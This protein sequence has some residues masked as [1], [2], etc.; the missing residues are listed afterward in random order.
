M[1]NLDQKITEQTLDIIAKAQTTGFNTSTGLYSYDL[2]P[3]LL[4]LIPVVVPFRDFVSR[5]KSTDGNKFAIWRAIMD[6]TS[7]QPDPSPGFEQAA[8][9]IVTVEQDFQAVYKPTGLGD[10]VSQDAI[11]LATGFEDPFAVSIF[12]TLNNVLIAD[13]RK[14]IGAQS[15]PLPTA[16]APVLTGLT[17][18]GSI[19]AATVAYVAAAG[20]TGSGYYYGSGNSRATASAQLTA[21]GSGAASISAIVPS[22]K[23]AVAYDW[24]YST[25]GTTWFYYTTTSTNIVTVTRVI[26]ANQPLPVNLASLSNVWQGVNGALPTANFVGDNGSANANDYDGFLATLSGDYNTAGQFVQAGTAIVNPGTTVSL[27]G[28][29]LSMSG[30]TITQIVQSLFLPIFNKTY[31]SPT[32]LMMNAAQAYEIAILVLGSTAATTFI[33]TASPERIS[34]TAGGRV[35]KIINPFG[36]GNTGGIEVAIEV[37]PAVPP[38]TIIARTDRVP[39]PNANINSVLEYRALRDTN[40]FDYGVSRATGANGGPRR[41]YEIRSLGAFVNRAPVSMGVLQNVG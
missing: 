6:A 2:S 32:V 9:Q 20:R 18:G 38:G 37:H 13:D 17:T 40:Q 12:N 23:G 26:T 5:K 1:S 41:Q 11:D 30:G 16:G 35:G 27:D 31:L 33:S 19:P 15:F 22:V 4:S 34:T 29:V 28:A 3:E 21:T 7:S 24:F 25:N 10:S 8:G 39:F 36:A 14:L